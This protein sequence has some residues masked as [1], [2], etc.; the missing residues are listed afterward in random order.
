MSA[1][2]LGKLNRAIMKPKP[3][4]PDSRTPSDAIYRLDSMSHKLYCKGNMP[5]GAVHVSG[6]KFLPLFMESVTSTLTA[7]ATS[8]NSVCMSLSHPHRFAPATLPSG[9]P[10][11]DNRHAEAAPMGL[12][13]TMSR[14]GDSEDSNASQRE[15]EA[16]LAMTNIVTF[17]LYRVKVT[18]SV[19]LCAD[20]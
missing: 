4:V 16:L 13:S 8:G 14:R 17:K 20:Y 19:I 9:M 10:L 1:L 15:F 2:D 3:S 5:S 12:E 11:R 18:K 7:M 6:C